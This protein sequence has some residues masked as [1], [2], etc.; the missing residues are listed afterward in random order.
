MSSEQSRFYPEEFKRESVKLAL[1]TDKTISEVAFS[2]GK[3]RYTS[4]L[5]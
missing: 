2:L 5:D 4:R 1:G 3:D